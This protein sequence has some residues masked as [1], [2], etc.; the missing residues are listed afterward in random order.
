MTSSDDPTKTAS[1]TSPEPTAPVRNVENQTQ[2]SGFGAPGILGR[3]RTQDQ[4]KIRSLALRG[5]G[6]LFS[7]LAFIIMATRGG[8]RA[9]LDGLK[10]IT[11]QIWVKK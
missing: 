2:A 7:F 5:L 10:R 9:G 11:G 4:Q 6:L 8:K 1:R 3:W